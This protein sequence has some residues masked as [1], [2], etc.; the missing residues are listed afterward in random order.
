P[1]LRERWSRVEAL[2]L[3]GRELP[4]I[5]VYRVGDV[6]FVRDGHHRVSVARRLGQETIRANVIEVRTRV[7]L[8]SEVNAHELLR[9]A[10][11]A[12]FLEMTQLDRLCPE[13]RLECMHL[14]HYDVIYE[15]ILGHRYLLSHDRG[16]EVPMPEAVVS[17]YTTVYRPVMEVVRKHRIAEH[18]PEWTEGD[19]YLAV[20]RRWL[21]L[22]YEDESAGPEGAGVSLLHEAE[23]RQPSAARLTMLRRW[24]RKRIRRT[25]VLGTVL[26]PRRRRRS[27]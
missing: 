26:T 12:S 22:S 10:E 5:E 6:Y 23:E 3:Q 20:T 16:H 27:S 17:W 25:L 21:E 8:G 7:P 15:H 2:M 14:G 19:L 13:A 11:Y 1:R 9:S 18:F 24:L 4:P